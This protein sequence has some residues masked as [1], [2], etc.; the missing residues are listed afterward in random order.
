M[1]YTLTRPSPIALQWIESYAPNFL[2]PAAHSIRGLIFRN[3][4]NSVRLLDPTTRV[5]QFIRRRHP[6]LC[7][8]H[9]TSMPKLQIYLTHHMRMWFR[10]TSSSFRNPSYI[11]YTCKPIKNMFTRI[12]VRHTHH[13]SPHISVHG[14]VTPR[15]IYQFQ[16]HRQHLRCAYAREDVMLKFVQFAQSSNDDLFASMRAVARMH[17]VHT[18]LGRAHIMHDKFGDYARFEESTDFSWGGR[19]KTE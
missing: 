15:Q 1:E 4:V 16:N 8:S 2:G 9:R 14:N 12:T 18:K 10:R 11:V 6:P 7:T 19:E 17:D 13:I 5:Q 3:S